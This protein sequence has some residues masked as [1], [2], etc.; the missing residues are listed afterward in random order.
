MKPNVVSFFNS[1]FMRDPSP[2]QRRSRRF[3]SLS[4]ARETIDEFLHVLYNIYLFFILHVMPYFAEKLL[5]M[6]LH[7]E[8]I[9]NNIHRF[10]LHMNMH[11]LLH[12]HTYIFYLYMYTCGYIHFNTYTTFCFTPITLYKI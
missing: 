4:L 11:M 7:I 1:P 2:R 5:Q 12:I 3:R 6:L 8:Y 9:Y 10:L